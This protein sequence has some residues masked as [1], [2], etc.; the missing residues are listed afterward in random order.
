MPSAKRRYTAGVISDLLERP[1]AYELFQAVR[2]LE[3]WLTSSDGSGL[4]R[5][6]FINS[7]SLAF[8]TGDIERLQLSHRANLEAPVHEDGSS[9]EDKTV[10]PQRVEKVEITTP[11]LSLL[12]VSGALP[13]YYTEALLQ[14]QQR[15]R[16]DSARAFMDV[17]SHRAVLL[18]YEAWRKNRLALQYERGF[19][20]V[21]MPLLL[22]IA[23]VGSPAARKQW[24][25]AAAHSLADHPLAYHAG[26]LQQRTV[27]AGQ[28]QQALRV[29]FCVPVAVEQFIGGW[30]TLPPEC[31]F[32]LGKSRS[33][34]TGS[35]Q[36]LLGRSLM[37]GERI[38]QRDLCVRLTFGPLRRIDFLR[39]L[40]GGCGA[41]ALRRFLLLMLG[42]SLDHEV[43]LRL[44]ARD[45]EGCALLAQ[46][47]AE[48]GRLGWDTFLIT[49]PMS[50]ERD[51]VRYTI[52]FAA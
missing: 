5:L 47:P 40:P 36:G 44:D 46:R 29:Q 9:I 4:K 31:R 41:Q 43:R 51:D 33:Q 12:G 48:Q 10:P 17:F 27:S 34:Q 22:S 42:P 16:D 15:H 18:F 39:L 13:L 52:D 25:G 8:P 3:R 37:L 2:L 23:G 28:L 30:Y 14:F 32:H 6:S 21:F 24:R 50:A 45:V 26:Q 7:M 19:D 11:A 20:H 49:K 1:Q 35:E 38:W